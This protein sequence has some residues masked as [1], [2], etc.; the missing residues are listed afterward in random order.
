MVYV[1]S[2]LFAITDGGIAACLNA[3]TGELVWQQRVGGTFSASPVVADGRIYLVSDNCETIV[4]RAGGTYEVLARNSL[5]GAVQSS[6]AIS[7]GQIFIRTEKRLYAIGQ[8]RK[9]GR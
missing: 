4:I 5:E 3:L 6:P 1:N 2:Y 8:P 9:A 7:Q